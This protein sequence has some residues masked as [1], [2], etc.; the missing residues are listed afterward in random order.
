MRETTKWLLPDSEI[1]DAWLNIGHLVKDDYPL[2]VEGRTMTPMTTAKLAQ[3]YTEECAK[4]DM[5]D[6]RYRTNLHISVP[7]EVMDEYRKYRCTPLVRARGLERALGYEGRIFYKTEA[8]NPGGS[9][10]P[11]TAIPQLYYAREQGLKGVV[12]DTGA[13][14]WG[15]SVAMAARRFGLSCTV[16]M[17]RNSYV[18]KPY[19]RYMMELAGA[20]VHS[21]PSNLTSRG[22]KLLADN[23]EHSG[24]LGIGLGEAMEL[25]QSDPTLRL[26]LGCMSYHAALHQTVIGLELVKQLTAAEVTPDVLVAC[27]GGGTNFFGLVAPWLRAKLTGEAGPVLLAAESASAPV[28]TKGEYRYDYADTFEYTPQS[29]MFTLGH[30]FVPPAAHAGG[31]RYHGKSAILSLMVKKG[32]VAA[33]AIS[34]EDAF[35]AGRLFF[36]TEGVLVAPESAHAIAAVAQQVK[37]TQA[38]GTKKDFVFCLSG[39]GYLDLVGYAKMFGLH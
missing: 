31:L 36:D 5:L 11:N 38:S 33:T 16:F 15:A 20:A 18:D 21:S 39:S 4:I 14:Q 8:G 28:F 32:L 9:H 1:P 2:P 29:K 10:K 24:S 19:R 13:G 37:Q 6:G 34:Q 3:L 25:G 30:E 27:V 35:A 7:G 22:R 12:T 23:P 26:C 17:T